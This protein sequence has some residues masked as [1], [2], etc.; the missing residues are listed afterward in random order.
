MHYII[1]SLKE[2]KAECAHLKLNPALTQDSLRAIKKNERKRV[3]DETYY[4]NL[5]YQFS[6]LSADE[7]LELISFITVELIFMNFP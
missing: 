2:R 3:K 5:L 4:F 7:K 6:R 1:D